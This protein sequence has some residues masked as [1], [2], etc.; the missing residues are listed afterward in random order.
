[1]IASVA[2]KGETELEKDMFNKLMLPIMKEDLITRQNQQEDL[3]QRFIEA[4]TDYSG[5][6]TVDQLWNLM[7]N[8]GA[9]VTMDEVIELMAEIDVDRNGRLDIQEF[10]S[11]M[12]LGNQITFTA[13][14]QNIYNKI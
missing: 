3:R 7:T 14:S 4:D 12:T 11:L 10:I 1:M 6:L 5:F 8:M 2:K 9:L 13:T